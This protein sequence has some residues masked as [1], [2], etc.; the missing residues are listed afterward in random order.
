[1]VAYMGSLMKKTWGGCVVTADLLKSCYM[2]G[3]PVPHPNFLRPES[4]NTAARG[5][6]EVSRI[7]FFFLEVVEKYNFFSVHD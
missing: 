5:V 4:T 3:G 6:D 1:M 2:Y 7:D